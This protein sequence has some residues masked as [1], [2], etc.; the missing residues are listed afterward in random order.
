[1]LKRILPA[2]ALLLPGVAF[3]ADPLPVPKLLVLD[4]N[5][6]IEYSKAGQDIAK[7][8]QALTEQAK[9]DLAGQGNA[10][11]KEG[12]QLQQQVAILAP[13]LKKQRIDAFEAKQRAFQGAAQRKDQQIRLAYLNARNA[14]EQQVLPIL[15]QLVTERGANMVLDKQ[16]VVLANNSSYDITADIIARLNA[17]MPGYK[18][19]LPAPPPQK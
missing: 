13:D 15:Q 10:L 11:E 16:V 3:A 2:L 1:M 9:R 8:M 19:T 18:V 7:Q 5:A 4:R 12:Q 17:K 6:L 14:V